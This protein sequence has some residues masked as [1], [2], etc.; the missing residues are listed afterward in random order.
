MLLTRP[1][2]PTKDSELVPCLLHNGDVEECSSLLSNVLGFGEII[3]PEDASILER[4]VA[5]GAL[6]LWN[7]CSKFFNDAENEIG[8]RLRSGSRLHF[9]EEFG[10]PPHLCVH[11]NHSIHNGSFPSHIHDEIYNNSEDNF[12]NTRDE[13]ADKVWS[14]L[15]ENIRPQP[16]SG[17]SGAAAAV[18]SLRPPNFDLSGRQSLIL[19]VTERSS[20]KLV[21]TAELALKPPD[22]QVCA[23]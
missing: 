16:I 1:I 10:G 19:A 12:E 13:F 23:T 17:D 18:G 6:R 2:D 14:I 3:M 11:E 9:S 21:A 8:L 15:A 5:D 22:G 7:S 20:G 4:A